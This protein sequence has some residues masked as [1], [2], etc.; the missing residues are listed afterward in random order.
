VYIAHRFYKIYKEAVS[1]IKVVRIYAPPYII[2]ASWSLGM[3]IMFLYF[4][5]FIIEFLYAFL[6]VNYYITFVLVIGF[7][8][9]RFEFVGKLFDVYSLFTLKNALK[10]AKKY[11][12]LVDVETYPVGS[13]QKIDEILENIWSCKKYPV[14][15][16]RRLE[17]A[18]C[19]KKID[20][21]RNLIESMQKTPEKT[22]LY[23]ESIK[24]L[25]ERIADYKKKIEMIK[26]KID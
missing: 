4:S 26:E 21:C 7:I 23:E 19:E 11:A 1:L 24:L 18:L 20:E 17:I 13:D 14:M 3:T 22:P 15:H 9:S 8:L 2:L 25:K 12:Y 6:F 10:I 16:V 5:P